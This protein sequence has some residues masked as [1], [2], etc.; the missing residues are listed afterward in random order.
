MGR[1]TQALDPDPACP[2]SVD[3]GVSGVS[4]GTLQSRDPDHEFATVRCALLAERLQGPAVGP[5]QFAHSRSREVFAAATIFRPDAGPS[6]TP[7]RITPIE[8][9]RGP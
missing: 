1:S 2:A 3:F 5:G 7:T 4:P 8:V 6:G 9:S